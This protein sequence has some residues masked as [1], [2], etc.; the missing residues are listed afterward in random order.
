MEWVD[1]T[2]DVVV[3][4]TIQWIEKVFG[5][6]YKNPKPLGIR[7]NIARVLRDS[8]GTNKQ[9]HTFTVEIID[10]KGDEPLTSGLTTTRKGRNLYRF[11]TKRQLWLDESKRGDALL[12]KHTRGD[13]ARE[14]RAKRRE[15]EAYYG[16]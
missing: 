16:F 12:E 5:G 2:G 1:C 13:V 9:Q 4:D 3:G 10:S 15:D 8:Y 7:T 14:Q 11:M 6:S